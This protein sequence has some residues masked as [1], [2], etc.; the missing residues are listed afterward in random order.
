M[1]FS[2]LI[3]V[4]AVALL[5]SCS[6]GSHDTTALTS[7]QLANESATAMNAKDYAKAHTMAKEA[8]RIDPQFAEAWVSYGMASVSLGQT[9]QARHAYERALSLYQARHIQNPS[10][11]NPVFQQVFVLTLLGRPTEA[12]TLLKQAHADYPN[13]QQ[14]TLAAGDY[15]SMK[16]RLQG[17]IVGIRPVNRHYPATR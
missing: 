11:A 7:Q 1:K 6:S 9:N 14:I 17:L 8:T 4:L 3:P 12:Q 15:V 13:D 2:H 10:D 5:T 16:E